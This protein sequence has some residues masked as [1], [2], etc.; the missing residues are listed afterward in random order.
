VTILAPRDVNKAV[1]PSLWGLQVRSLTKMVLVARHS[2][3]STTG[4]RQRRGGSFGLD[5]VSALLLMRGRL[6]SHGQLAAGRH[7][8][9]R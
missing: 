9:S 1:V 7:C 3:D 8:A 2:H 5:F 4:T 6:R